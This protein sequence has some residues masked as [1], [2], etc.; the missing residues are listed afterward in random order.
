MKWP[1]LSHALELGFHTIGQ[2]RRDTAPHLVPQP[3]TGRGRPRKYVEK[4]SLLNE[5]LL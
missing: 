5:L 3:Q 4:N 1:Y 2:V